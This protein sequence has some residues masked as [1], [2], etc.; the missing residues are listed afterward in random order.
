MVLKPSFIMRTPV[1]QDGTPTF[2]KQESLGP[3]ALRSQKQ[4]KMRIRIKLINS[5]ILLKNSIISF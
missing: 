5:Q 1:L 4:L 3:L 2:I